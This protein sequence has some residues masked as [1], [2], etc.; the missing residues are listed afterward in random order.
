ML[1][2]AGSDIAKCFADMTDGDAFAPEQNHPQVTQTL[3]IRIHKYIKESCCNE[4]DRNMLPFDQTRQL[5]DVQHSFF[6][7]QNQ[8][9]SIG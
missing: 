3:D 7:H 5:L 9:G 2:F 6:W 4:H 8:S 1:E